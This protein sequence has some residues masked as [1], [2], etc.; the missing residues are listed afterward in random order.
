MASGELAENLDAGSCSSVCFDTLRTLQEQ[1]GD[2]DGELIQELVEVFS[3]DANETQVRLQELLVQSDAKALSGEAHRLK[4][5]AANLGATRLTALCK[6]LEHT[7]G[8]GDLT[9][10]APLVKDIAEEIPRTIAGLGEYVAS[11]GLA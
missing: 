10:S 7:A 4:S 2:E 11:L 6:D 5:G 3:E 8:A 1:T 9:G